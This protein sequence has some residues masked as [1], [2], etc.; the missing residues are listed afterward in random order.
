MPYKFKSDSCLMNATKVVTTDII[1][2]NKNLKA[3]LRTAVEVINKRGCCSA[4]GEWCEICQ[5][6][7]SEECDL[8][9][10]FVWEDTAKAN[11][12]IRGV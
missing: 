2:E 1:N 6:Q 7:T 3:M 4:D 10:E 9:K 8:Y 11:K 5:C 12:L